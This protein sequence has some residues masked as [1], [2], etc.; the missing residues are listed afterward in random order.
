ME[1]HTNAPMNEIIE[2]IAKEKGFAKVFFLPC[3]PLDRHIFEAQKE[4]Q[5]ASALKLPH[6]PLSVYPWAKCVLL[7]IWAYEP[8]APDERIPAYYLASNKAYH[9]AKE[10]A[11]EIK[12]SGF[13]SELINLPA[14]SLAL[15]NGIG[16]AGKNG[17]LALKGLGTRIALYTLVTDACGPVKPNEPVPDECGECNACSLACPAGAIGA[18]LTPVK[19]MRYEMDTGEHPE[20]VNAVMPG[21]L[22]CEICQHVCPKNA[23]L[24]VIEPSDDVK[25]AF[26]L[27]RLLSGDDAEARRLAGKNMTKEGK[28][29]N[30]ARVFAQRDGILTE[31]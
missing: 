17:L 27:K 31:K 13:R 29:I 12:A 3:E 11:A 23:G 24:R 19:C 26:E 10:V 25:R 16:S 20:W 14:R 2:S 30:E 22:G 15:Q 21:F 7:L 8:F 5:V 9:A 1:S 18:G 6:D 28:L 4:G